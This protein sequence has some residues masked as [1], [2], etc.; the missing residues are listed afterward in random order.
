MYRYEY[1][2]V[3][4]KSGFTKVTL[5]EHRAIIDDHAQRGFRYVGLIPTK[6]TGYGMLAEVDLIFEK[7]E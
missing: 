2:T 7:N 4:V 5:S 3:G 6:E 1:V